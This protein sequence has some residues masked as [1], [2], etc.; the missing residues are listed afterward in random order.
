MAELNAL[1]QQHRHPLAIARFEFGII[2]DVDDVDN[3]AELLS[4]RQQ[5]L[6]HF[7]AKMA[8][9]AREKR[10]PRQVNRPSCRAAP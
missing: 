5:R 9:T 3:S 4:Q 7:V 2:I 6:R 1:M 8:I 10:Q